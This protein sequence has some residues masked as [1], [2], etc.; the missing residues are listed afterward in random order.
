MTLDKLKAAWKQYRLECAL[1]GISRN[2]IL[3]AIEDRPEVVWYRQTTML[4]NT[5]VFV[6]LLLCCQGG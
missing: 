6:F 3:S 4:V 2:E 5:G 1:Q